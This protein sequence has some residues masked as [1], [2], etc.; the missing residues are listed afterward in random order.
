MT[1]IF[2]IY[3]IDQGFSGF[4]GLVS[5]FI[6]ARAYFYRLFVNPHKSYKSWLR[7]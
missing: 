4:A 2:W 5:L 1:R 6:K 7:N 3:K